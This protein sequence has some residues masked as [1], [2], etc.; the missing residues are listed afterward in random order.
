MVRWHSTHEGRHLKGRR[1]SDTHPEILL[2]RALHALGVRF[3]LHRHIAKGCTP[4]IVL[5]G[6]KIAVFVDGDFW[7]S[8]PAH[9]RTTPFVGPNAEFWA[10]K[11]RTNRERDARSTHLAE[12]A[13]WQ[14]V[15]VWECRIR[16]DPVGAARATLEGRTLGPADRPPPGR[17]STQ[18]P[19]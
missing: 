3:R 7:H 4:D 14:V 6:R 10:E 16:Q 12:Q 2:R 8:C 19:P 11:M 1:K 5:P 15:R 18:D 17:P 9:G 13:G